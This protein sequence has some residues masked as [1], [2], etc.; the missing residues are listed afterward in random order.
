MALKPMKSTG[1]K[2]GAGPSLGKTDTAGHTP[3]TKSTGSKKNNGPATTSKRPGKS[4]PTTKSTKANSAYTPGFTKK[5][6]GHNAGSQKRGR[7]PAGVGSHL[8]T[9]GSGVYHE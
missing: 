2:G 4:L 7:K 8:N 9:E 1:K 3:K 5:D 6:V